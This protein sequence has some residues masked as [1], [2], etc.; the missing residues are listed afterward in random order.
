V[1]AER[2]FR[3]FARRAVNLPAIVATQ[4]EGPKPAR[5]VDLGLGGACVE[6]RPRTPVSVGAPVTVEVTAPNLWDPLIVPAKI[7]WVRPGVSGAVLAGLAF[8]HAGKSALPALVELLAAY[9]YE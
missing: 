8:D 1:A 6:L 5:L 4:A 7:A 9:R 2:H 3:A